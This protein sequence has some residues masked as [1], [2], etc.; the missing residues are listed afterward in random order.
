MKEKETR[1]LCIPDIKIGDCRL[2]EVLISHTHSILAHLGSK[3]MITYLRDNIWWHGLSADVHA[4]CKM[5]GVCASSKSSTHTPYGLLN[6]LEI[7]D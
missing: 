6:P 2:R 1:L 7:P 3:K 4:Y 5:C